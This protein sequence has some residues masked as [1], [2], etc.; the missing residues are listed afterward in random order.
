MPLPHYPTSAESLHENKNSVIN[1][2]LVFLY[3]LGV[4]VQ[5]PYDFIFK[6]ISE[7]FDFYR[8]VEIL[9]FENCKNVCYL[10]KAGKILYCVIE[11]TFGGT[12]LLVSGGY[13]FMLDIMGKKHPSVSYYDFK[14]FTKNILIH[15]DV[16]FN[17]MVFNLNQQLDNPPKMTRL[18]YL[19]AKILGL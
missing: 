6:N 10:D 8:K 18:E 19:N 4:P 11:N 17:G 5:A 15:K 13:Y 3:F 12:D 2:R 14:D 16:V 1:K 7:D 9:D